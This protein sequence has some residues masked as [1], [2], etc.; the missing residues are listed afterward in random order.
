MKLD[1]KLKM[2]TIIDLFY[3]QPFCYKY[4]LSLSKVD[5]FKNS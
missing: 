5:Y 1:K 4:I 3:D 2:S